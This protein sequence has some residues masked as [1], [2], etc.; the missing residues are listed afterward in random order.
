MTRPNVLNLIVDLM[1]PLILLGSVMLVQ[2]INYQAII[3]KVATILCVQS[4]KEDN[5]ISIEHIPVTDLPVVLRE[6]I[7]L[8][9]PLRK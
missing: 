6:E 5:L 2:N 8:H 4:M 3:D 7:L 9:G 1:K